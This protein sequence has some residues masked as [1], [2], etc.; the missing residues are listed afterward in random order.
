M[1]VKYLRALAKEAGIRG[2]SDMNKT[3]LLNALA[4]REAEEREE[5]PILVLPGTGLQEISVSYSYSLK[6]NMG[7]YESAD[8][9]ISRSERYGVAG[10]SQEEVDWLWGQRY[11]ALKALIDPLVEAE[12][13]QVSQFAEGNDKEEPSGNDD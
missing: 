6:A 12:Y 7:G 10:M 3:G 8:V 4:V 5:N 1:P 9:H 2:Y 11:E 13:A